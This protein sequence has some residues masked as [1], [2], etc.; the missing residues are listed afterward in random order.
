MNPILREA[1]KKDRLDWAIVAREWGYPRQIEL[2]EVAVLI[3]IAYCLV[4]ERI[5]YLRE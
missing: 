5:N 2:V 3:V 4:A 1:H